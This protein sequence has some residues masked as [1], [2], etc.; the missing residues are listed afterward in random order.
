MIC[1][2]DKIDS[3]IGLI[4]LGATDE[5]LIYCGNP[6]E[7]GSDIQDWISTYLPDC[8]LKHES[9]HILNLA[10]TQLKAYFSGE[11]RE[12]NV[13]LKLIGTPFRKTV[14]QALQ[15]IPYGETRSYGEIAAQI[16]KPKAPR[17]VGQA[18]HHNPISYFVPWHRV[19]GAGG[20]LVGFGGGLD[21]KA[22]LL[23]LEGIEYKKD[24]NRG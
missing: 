8:I 11:R 2:W 17:A 6:R 16:G 13:P 10:K 21:A 19:I 18:N 20:A 3:P 4:Y 14:W 23:D 15:T 9:N 22:W 5:G 12:L 1:Y 7:N 24:K